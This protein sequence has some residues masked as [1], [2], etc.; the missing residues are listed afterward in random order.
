MTSLS[1]QTERGAG[2]RAG[3]RDRRPVFALLSANA[4]SLSGN[5]LTSLAIPWFVLAT[6]G[7]ASKTGLVAFTQMLPTVLAAFLGGALV[8]RIGPKQ[9]SVFADLASGITVGLVPL[10]YHTVGLAFWQL[11]ILVFLGAVLDTPGNTAREALLPELVQRA[12]TSLE[13]ANGIMQTIQ[14]SSS[15]VGPVLAGLLITHLGASNVLWVDAATFAVSA[16][17]IGLMVPRL[18]RPVQQRGRYRDE[19]LDGL[20]FLRQ[21]RL[22]LTIIVMAAILN[23]VGPPTFTV[24]MPVF[25]RQE[26]GSAQSLGVILAGFGAGSLLGGAAF[27]IL[28]ARLPRRMTT[29]ALLGVSSVAIAGMAWLPAVAIATLL[30]GVF[31][32]AVGSVN[33]MIYTLL[34]ERAPAEFRGRIFGTVLGIALLAAPAGMLVAGASVQAFGVRAVFLAVAVVQAAV[35][36]ATLL[37]PVLKEMDRPQFAA[38]AGDHGGA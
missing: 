24:V 16:L 25:A 32:F 38:P 3:P 1:V 7:S 20:R 5:A 13:R 27:S 12:G 31:G 2:E 4:I 34:Q 14:S 26:F 35:T 30:T 28:G 6:T 11:L 9:M 37:Q 19:V 36:L 8:D 18:P 21:D 10:L 22:V 29:I 15:L 17:L 23:F 33:P